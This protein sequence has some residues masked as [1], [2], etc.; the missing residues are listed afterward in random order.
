MAARSAN[1]ARMTA[2]GSGTIAYALGMSTRKNG[3]CKSVSKRELK[4]ISSA[5]VLR[6]VRRARKSA[7]CGAPAEAV[8]A[9]KQAILARVAA[10]WQARFGRPADVYRFDLVSVWERA[11][12][13]ASVEH[14]PDAWRT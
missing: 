8:S 13:G 2:S 3:G 10:C 12:G 9:R 11:P 14:V 1:A 4:I 7:E 6:S 5:T